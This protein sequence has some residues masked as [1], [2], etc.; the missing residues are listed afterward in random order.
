MWLTV[1][2]IAYTFGGYWNENDR[3]EIDNWNNNEAVE[4]A[5]V[6]VDPKR[7]A[8]VRHMRVFLLFIACAFI[9]LWESFIIL[10]LLQ[11]QLQKMSFLSLS[12]SLRQCG[13]TFL[14]GD[15]ASPR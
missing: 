10:S 11:T 12:I 6:S 5:G 1:S 13:S 8:Q 2:N 14:V 9:L 7:V 4:N 3:N 15:H